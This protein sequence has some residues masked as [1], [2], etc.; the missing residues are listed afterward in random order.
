[1]YG[2]ITGKWSKAEGIV[3]KL[4]VEY[5]SLI[6]VRTLSHSSGWKCRLW[7]WNT[8]RV[9]KRASQD[10]QWIP[11]TIWLVFGWLFLFF[12]WRAAKR[13]GF[14]TWK[15][16]RASFLQ[17]PFYSDSQPAQRHSKEAESRFF[18]CWQDWGK[19]N[20]V[21]HRRNVQELLTKRS[22]L[23]YIW[24]KHI[25]FSH[26]SVFH[27]WE[28]QQ[29]VG[30][31]G[32]AVNVTGTFYPQCFRSAAAQGPAEKSLAAQNRLKV[33]TCRTVPR[34]MFLS[35]MSITR[36]HHVNPGLKTVKV[37]MKGKW[38]ETC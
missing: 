38:V 18:W 25:F 32:E 7:T 21:M 36:S 19:L 1:M 3:R 13:F 27:A 10:V 4:N 16:K 9:L 29:R 5:K 17:P 20:D 2:N 11:G 35:L 26:V 37:K 28:Q 33:W 31:R 8:G 34:R 22:E 14:S 6:L 15:S 12:L 30:Q 24:K 23:L